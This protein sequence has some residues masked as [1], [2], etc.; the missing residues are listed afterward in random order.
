MGHVEG[1]DAEAEGE[2]EG[3]IKRVQNIWQTGKSRAKGAS[4][5]YGLTVGVQNRRAVFEPT[6]T[7]GKG[8]KTLIIWNLKTEDINKIKEEANK[9]GLTVVECP[10][11]WPETPAVL[12][13]ERAL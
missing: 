3:F 1:F 2:L 7:T 5:R 12:P 9:I 4:I 13:R 8:M 6:V 10:Y 11:L